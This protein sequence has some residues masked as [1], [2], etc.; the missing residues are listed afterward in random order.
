MS[1]IVEVPDVATLAR[2]V[3]MDATD[4]TVKAFP[5]EASRGQ[6]ALDGLIDSLVPVVVFAFAMHSK[7]GSFRATMHAAA[8]LLDA[9]AEQTA[10]T[11][12]TL[13]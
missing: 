7:R 3:L 10:I 4:A 12:E 8:A 9:L 2:K 13:Q 5:D 6:W 1:R 11:M